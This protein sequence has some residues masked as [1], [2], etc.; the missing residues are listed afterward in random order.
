V[1]RLQ[2]G[3][4]EC[5]EAFVVGLARAGD[6]DAYA[7]LVRR[8]QS[9]IRNLMRRCCG[10]AALADDLAQQ[11]FLQAWLNVSTLREIDAF[12]G[13]LRRLSVSIWLQ[14]VRKRQLITDAPAPD[15]E[16][17]LEDLPDIGLDLDHALSALPPAVRLCIVL[18]YHEGM[19]HQE[20][21]EATGI[22]LGTVKSHITRGSKRLQ[23]ML[24]AYR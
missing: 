24:L 10:N 19:S 16:P 21:A 20:V 11:S 7:E 1:H 6:R 22:P 2:D 5:A 18:S 14:Y 9:T 3:Y 15:D 13:W 23:R 8:Y 17:S 4:A 12:G